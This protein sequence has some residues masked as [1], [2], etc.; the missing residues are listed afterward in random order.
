M[1]VVNGRPCEDDGNGELRS[2]LELSKQRPMQTGK[3][4]PPVPKIS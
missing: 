3:N 2:I 4:G 1:T